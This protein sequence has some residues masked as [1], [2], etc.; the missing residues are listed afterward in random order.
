MEGGEKKEK[1]G[2]RDGREREGGRKEEGRGG[3]G[4]ET[5]HTNLTLLPAPLWLRGIE[6]D[7]NVTQWPMWLMQRLSLVLQWSLDQSGQ[8]PI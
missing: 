1:G 8:T 2:G 3:K 4:G 6:T 5:H 7:I